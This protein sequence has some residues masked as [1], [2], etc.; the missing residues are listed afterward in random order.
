MTYLA[1]SVMYLCLTANVFMPNSCKS[2]NLS[3]VKLTKFDDSVFK[4]NVAPPSS[5]N[6]MTVFSK[7]IFPPGLGSKKG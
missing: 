1:K 5:L 2:E 7:K 6:L 4:E 3:A